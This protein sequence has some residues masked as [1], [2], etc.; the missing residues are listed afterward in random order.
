MGEGVTAVEPCRIERCTPGPP[1]GIVCL[2]S[3][4]THHATAIRRVKGFVRMPNAEY[5]DRIHNLVEQWK[6]E[7]YDHTLESHVMPAARI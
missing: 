4:F 2:K 6:D 3:E 5:E 7:I 1:V